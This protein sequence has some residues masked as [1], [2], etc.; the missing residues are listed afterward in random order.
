MPVR[1]YQV[2]GR[3]IPT[4]Q[5]PEP[6][7]YRMRIFAPN[8]VTAKSRFWYFLHKFH[9]LKKT[10][11]EILGVNEVR[12]AASLAA[13]LARRAG[14]GRLRGRE[15]ARFGWRAQCWPPPPALF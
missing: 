6:E 14:R 7:I 9:K 4:E 12:P 3:K 13:R 11:G 1:Y 8:D 15:K 10:T 2:V 5:D